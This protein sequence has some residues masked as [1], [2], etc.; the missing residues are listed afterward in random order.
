VDGG[1]ENDGV[2]K[3]RRVGKIKTAQLR[4]IEMNVKI[5]GYVARSDRECWGKLFYV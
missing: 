1:D 5:D 2:G 4:R 3:L